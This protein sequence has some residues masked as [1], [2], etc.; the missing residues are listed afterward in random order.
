MSHELNLFQEYLG[1]TKEWYE[2]RA[3]LEEG[4][5]VSAGVM[6]PF[7]AYAKV[8]GVDLINDPPFACNVPDGED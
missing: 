4:G 8:Y 1:L 7:E 3:K 5:E 2:Q 6:N